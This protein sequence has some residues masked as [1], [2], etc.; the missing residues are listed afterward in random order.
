MSVEDE[1]GHPEPPAT[2]GELEGAF[3]S[4]NK[5]DI[6]IKIAPGDEGHF[7][8]IKGSIYPEDKRIVKKSAPKSWL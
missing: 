8:M 7:I 5:R 6:K 2:L 1:R 3:A 4:V